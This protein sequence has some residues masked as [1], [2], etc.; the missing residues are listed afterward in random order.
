MIKGEDFLDCD[1][2]AR[3]FVKSSDNGAICAFAQD[4]EDTVI[5][6][7][8]RKTAGTWVTLFCSDV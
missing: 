8:Q 1:L 7:C 3:G 6:A 2:S 5:V 4:M